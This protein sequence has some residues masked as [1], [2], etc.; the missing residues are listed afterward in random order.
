[1]QVSERRAQEWCAAK[2]NI[3]YFETSAKE[4]YNVDEAFLCV[5]KTGLTHE[6]EQDMWV[7][8]KWLKNFYFLLY[9]DNRMKNSWKNT[10]YVAPY[11]SVFISIHTFA[12]TILASLS[13][14]FN[15]YCFSIFIWIICNPSNLTVSPVTWKVY[16]KLFQKQSREGGVHAK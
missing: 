2:G 5:A 8:Y 13:I 6:H 10:N 15:L 3:P 14:I 16:Q 9:L 12:T 4:D 7:H 1:M 11:S